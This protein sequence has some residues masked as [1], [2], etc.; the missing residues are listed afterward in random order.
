MAS[1]ERA[2]LI[3]SDTPLAVSGLCPSYPY[4]VGTCQ[5]RHTRKGEE[6]ELSSCYPALGEQVPVFKRQLQTSL[7]YGVGDGGAEPL[8]KAC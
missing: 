4:Y 2:Q 1:K 5:G 7:G 8:R 6:T 3:N